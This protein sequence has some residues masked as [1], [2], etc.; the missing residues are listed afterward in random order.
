MVAGPRSPPRRPEVDKLVLVGDLYVR[1]EESGGGRGTGTQEHK[2]GSR[3]RLT[4]SPVQ[5]EPG[6]NAS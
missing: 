3:V 1:E 6:K 2:E 5:W 4:K